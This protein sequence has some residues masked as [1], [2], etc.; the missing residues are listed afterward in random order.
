[1]LTRRAAGTGLA[2]LRGFIQHRQ[3][4]RRQGIMGPC[5]LVYGCRSMPDQICRCD[6]VSHT[7]SMCMSVMR[8]D[9]V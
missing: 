5:V 9:A 2:P 3:H 1:M 4:L 8:P 7:C 6:Q